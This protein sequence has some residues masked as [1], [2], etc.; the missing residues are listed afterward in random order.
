VLASTADAPRRL[1][2]FTASIP[3]RPERGSSY[4]F[5]RFAL[6]F[7]SAQRGGTM[8]GRGESARAAG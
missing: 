8:P 3:E 5:Q 2:S 6:G 1:P 4:Q 7:P